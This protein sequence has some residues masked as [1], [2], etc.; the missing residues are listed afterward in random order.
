MGKA[1]YIH[2][3]AWWRVAGW[4]GPEASHASKRAEGLGGTG[5][6]ASLRL[7]YFATSLDCAEGLGLLDDLGPDASRRSRPGQLGQPD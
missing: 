1:C 2:T 4:A 6:E 7:A 3:W 5:P